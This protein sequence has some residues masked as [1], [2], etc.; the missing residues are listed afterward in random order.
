MTDF[1]AETFDLGFLSCPLVPDCH[2]FYWR[3][4]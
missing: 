2:S 1:E 4:S 3:R